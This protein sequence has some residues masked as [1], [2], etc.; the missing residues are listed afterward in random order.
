MRPNRAAVTPIGQQDPPAQLKL[1]VLHQKKT[2][3]NTDFCF[4]PKSQFF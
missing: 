2:G 1:L 4:W 3:K